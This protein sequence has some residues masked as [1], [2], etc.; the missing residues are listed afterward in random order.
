MSEMGSARVRVRNEVRSGLWLALAGLGLGI[1]FIFAYLTLRNPLPELYTT[2]IHDG[3]QTTPFFYSV[4][5]NMV[6]LS[7][8]EFVVVTVAL[9]LLFAAALGVALR[10]AYTVEGDDSALA[11]VI[12][13]SAV[14]FSLTLL[15]M[16]PLFSQDVFDYIFQTRE[17]VFHHSNPFIHV[18]NDF[19]A[20]PFLK[21][22]AWVQMPS[23]YGPL[24]MIITAPLALL[25]G[26]SLLANLFYFKGLE[27]VA[28]LATTLL[29]YSTLG[30]V[31][32]RWQLAGTLLF[33]WNPLI[34]MEFAGS[35]H[36]DILMLFMVALACWL[37]VNQ[38][39]TLA[40]L[41]LTAGA[42]IK[43][44]AGFV[45][46]LFIIY[47]LIQPQMKGKRLSFLLRTGTLCLGSALLIYAP[48]WDGPDS[49][50][51][52]KL[53]DKLGGPI[54]TAIVYML[55]AAHV[56]RADAISW[57]KN[58]AWVAFALFYARQCWAL[59]C[60]NHASAAD[61]RVTR[62]AAQRAESLLARFAVGRRL[63]HRIELAELS[64]AQPESQFAQL[65]RANGMVLLF[66]LGAVS[67]YYQPWYL[68][69]SLFW[70]VFLVAPR[71][72][73]HSW[74]LLALSCIVVIAN[75]FA[76]ITGWGT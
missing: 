26:N 40:M 49:L 30:K 73:L 41:A 57:V 52:L 37:L 21:Y 4:S 5:S 33:A 53:G 1:E 55:D 39:F 17:W 34:L 19:A 54:P 7:R 10:R 42:L 59:W 76:G 75:V 2:I 6:L 67:L 68:S 63:L 62:W 31:Q 28:Y 18:P 9:A 32:P 56:S 61:W 71:Y 14:V 47:A 24:W 46:P 65:A 72:K 51:F 35:G 70:L 25:G 20:D 36:N 43:V 3:Q 8:P 23:T 69:W 13:G 45:L 64:A 50:A 38:R 60:G 11:A 29:I 16:Y 27:V 15:W 12:L 66:F 44:V 48:L 22:I 74:P 58:V